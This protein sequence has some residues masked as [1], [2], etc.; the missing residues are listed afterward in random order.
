MYVKVQPVNAQMADTEKASK[1][2]TR[3]LYSQ[4]NGCDDEY[5]VISSRVSS[6]ALN[7]LYTHLIW[8]VVE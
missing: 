4:K 8:F 5:S 3:V 1:F 2:L 7:C 6:S